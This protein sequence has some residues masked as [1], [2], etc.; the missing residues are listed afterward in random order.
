M[1]YTGRNVILPKFVF[2]F[3]TQKLCLSCNIMRL[4]NAEHE[5]VCVYVAGLPFFSCGRACWFMIGCNDIFIR[6]CGQWQQT[7][8]DSME[9]KNFQPISNGTELLKVTSGQISTAGRDLIRQMWFYFLNSALFS[10]WLSIILIAEN[11]CTSAWRTSLTFVC[12]NWNLCIID[13]Q[14]WL[15]RNNDTTGLT[16]SSKMTDF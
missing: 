2:Q 9:R 14:L 12:Q 3:C 16:Q 11:M 7:C 4:T 1:L 13:P 15:F 5:D 6:F 8:K 10:D